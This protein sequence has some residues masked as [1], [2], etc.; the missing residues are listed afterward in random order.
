MRIALGVSYQ[1]H[2][3]CGWQI[4]QDQPSVQATL[5]HAIARVANHEVKTIASGRTDTGVHAVGQVVHF[6]TTALRQPYQWQQGIN[7]HLPPDISVL[8]ARPMCEEF[9]A[10]FSA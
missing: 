1:G 4:Q 7:T 2:G 9:H 6:D 3:Y 8:W 5:E 10:R